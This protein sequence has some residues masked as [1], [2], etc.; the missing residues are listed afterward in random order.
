MKIKEVCQ[1]TGLSDRAIRFYVEQGLLSPQFTENYLGRRSYI[2]AQEDVNQLNSI[3]VL[4]KFGFTVAEIGLLIEDA[5]NSKRIIA[6]LKGRKQAE[7]EENMQT[8]EAINKLDTDTEYTIAE[9]ADKL[10]EESADKS[11]PEEDNKI[12]KKAMAVKITGYVL[13]G[14]SALYYVLFVFAKIYDFFSKEYPFFPVSCYD[15]VL[16]SLIPVGILLSLAFVKHRRPIK[17][18]IQIT[19]LTVCVLLVPYC[20]FYITL[21]PVWSQTNEMKNYKQFDAGTFESNSFVCDVFPEIRDSKVSRNEDGVWKTSYKEGQYFYRD[22]FWGFTNCADIYLEWELE[23]DEFDAEVE[24][25]RNW[26]E[27]I[28]KEQLFTEDFI[29][30]N[31]GDYI[32]LLSSKENAF[33]RTDGDLYWG[34][35]F[36]YNPKTLTVRYACSNGAYWNVEPYISELEW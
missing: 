31:K 2:F 35:L 3:A 7:L 5:A 36:A 25:V 1:R 28:G 18:W 17:R 11:V 26:Y 22:F 34:Y 27:T 30:V 6:E 16:I 20:T 29:T 12:N 8:L 24:R 10:T 15:R 32:C 33:Q 9:L 19:V 13:F 14:L 21:I 23:E 4:R